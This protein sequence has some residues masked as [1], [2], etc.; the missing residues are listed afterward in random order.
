MEVE[1]CCPCFCRLV[2]PLFQRARAQMHEWSTLGLPTGL[3]TGR[4]TSGIRDALAEALPM[5][6][7]SSK[8]MSSTI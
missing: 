1:P 5:H 6:R 2:K 7:S 8:G 4:H 3:L